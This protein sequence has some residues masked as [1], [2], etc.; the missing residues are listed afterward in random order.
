MICQPGSICWA[1]A[2][3]QHGR[4]GPQGPLFAHLTCIPQ[5]PLSRRRSQGLKLCDHQS[6]SLM[7]YVR[8]SVGIDW[9]IHSQDLVNGGSVKDEQGRKRAREDDR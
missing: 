5:L 8:A 9:I 3:G 4:A 2:G 7:L 6:D 1:V